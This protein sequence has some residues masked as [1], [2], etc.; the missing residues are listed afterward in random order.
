TLRGHISWLH[1]L[2]FSPDGAQLAT[3]GEDRTVR[4]W[5]AG[6]GEPAQT[7]WGHAASVQAVAFSLDG[8]RLASGD[9][10]GTIRV[11]DSASGQR[12]LTLTAPAGIRDLAFTAGDEQLLIGAED[13]IGRVYTFDLETLLELGQ[14]RRHH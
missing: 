14:A 5:D 10:A 4:L 2:A 12:L 3:A 8:T 1:D 13:G 11:W 7:L 9:A 6:S